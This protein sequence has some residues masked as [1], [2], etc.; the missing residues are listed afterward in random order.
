MSVADARAGVMRGWECT[1]TDVPEN[2][3]VDHKNN[4][5]CM[6]A[7]FIK[8][9]RRNTLYGILIFLMILI[10]LNVALTLWIVSALKL[11]MNGIGPIKIVKGGIQLEGH[12][13]VTDNLVAS[14]ITSQPAHP[15]SFQ[16]HRNFSV[17]VSDHHGV[18]HSKLLIKRDNIEFSGQVFHV[19]DSRGM[20][21]FHASRDEVR[22]FA[23][24]FAVDGVGGLV[25][26][27]AVQVPFV[28]APPGFDL[29]LESLTRRLDLRAPQSIHFESRAGGIDLTSQN[30]IKLNS[31]VGAIKIDSPNIVI[32]NLKEASITEKP[33][34]GIRGIKVYQLCA[35]ATGKLFL[36]APDAPC[37]ANDDDTD[38]CR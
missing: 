6:P 32:N 38:L 31:I 22:V 37:A 33:Q 36:A 1:P 23:D 13:W 28:R 17:Q 35:C 24:T 14:T 34:K 4:K 19:R 26:K 21:V 15:I 2:V 30:D 18:P 3:P 29:Q 11:S 27:N 8:G 20:N 12:S 10:F 5:T 7:T 9:W 16:S 25:V